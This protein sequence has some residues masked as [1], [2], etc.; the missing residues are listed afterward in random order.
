[1]ELWL[2]P[3]TILFHGTG[4][5]FPASEI[6]PGGYDGVLWTAE[7]STI[8]Q[9]Y[10]PK[11][12]SSMLFNSEMLRRPVKREPYI[13]LQHLIGIEYDLDNVEWNYM[14]EP[15]SFF[16]PPNWDHIPTTEEIEERLDRIGIERYK[17]PNSYQLR[18][19]FRENG[20]Y[21]IHQH[22]RDLVGRLFIFTVI[23]PLR[24]YDNTQ[25][26]EREG[27]LMNVEYHSLGLFRA[28]EEH[29]YDGI[30][31]NDFA[32]TEIWGNVGHTS[33][34][35]FSGALDK[36]EWTTIPAQ[37]FDWEENL[38]QTIS[39]EYEEYLSKNV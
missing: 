30:K 8:A 9:T 35:L 11:S 23:E 28:A 10:I 19:T 26:G 4:E 1:M 20:G 17:Y 2:E 21:H 15:K 6:Q 32:Q 34:G 14:D 12:G 3:G 36:V 22:G 33:I 18:A 7:A 29:G 24:I 16:M 25:G 27:D 13:T 38:N 31:I 5:E 37:N 39:P